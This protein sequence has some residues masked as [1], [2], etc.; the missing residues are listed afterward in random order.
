MD[1]MI[2]VRRTFLGM[3]IAWCGGATAWAKRFQITRPCRQCG[4][5]QRDYQHGSKAPIVV[6]VSAIAV[7]LRADAAA[8]S[9]ETIRVFQ[10]VD[11]P[12][13]RNGH[14]SISRVTVRIHQDRRWSV[15]CVAEQNVVDDQPLAPAPSFFSGAV[16][17]Q[18]YTAHLLRNQ[19]VI[20][21]RGYANYP[22]VPNDTAVTAGPPMMF[23]LEPPP[24]WVQRGQPRIWS[25]D[26]VNA[27]VGEFFLL[28]QRVEVE[29]SYM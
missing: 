11:Q 16:P 29:F 15:S 27:D 9:P 2:P 12:T 25:Y 21:L 13:L 24:F 5:P 6:A 8:T 18:P 20:R 19:F 28:A 10:V 3:L 17:P 1:S 4:V 22:V 7:P 26:G 14:C 23:L